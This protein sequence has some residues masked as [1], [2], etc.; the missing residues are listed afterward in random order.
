MFKC[1]LSSTERPLHPKEKVLEQALQWCKM[2]DPS[3][4]YLVVKRV[5]KGE[6]FNILTAYK[7]EIMKMGVL[8][9]R[10]E[11]PKLLHGK[12]FQEHTFQI[13]D[14]K[15]L[16]LK[17]KKSIKPEKEWPLKSMKIYMG[18]RK[19][20]KPPTR[21]G[22]TLMME[23]QHLYLCCF[24]ESDLWDWVT[25]FLKAQND[26]PRPPVLRRHSSSDISKQKFGTMPLVPIRGD[27][28]ESNST[29]LSANQ[30]LRKLHAR[31]TLSMFFPMKVQPDSFEERPEST[32]PEPPEPL[33]EEVGDFGLQVLKS[34]ETSFLSNNTSE[35]QEVPD[36][37]LS[38]SLG[39]RKTCSLDRMIGPKP[40][41]SLRLGGEGLLPPAGSLDTLV[42][43]G[44]GDLQESPQPVPRRRQ[45]HRPCTNLTGATPPGTVLRLHQED[46]E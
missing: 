36:G 35:T 46:R 23:K 45:Q 9:C 25:N 1:C 13:K 34:L 22:F 17:D 16:L 11:P 7:S 42:L 19:K 31:R 37:P 18:I 40:V 20:L 29:M 4:A 15:L 43:G 39:P 5:P 3:S 27:G 41:H 28:H 26:D 24:C 38:L 33:Y 2:A 12:V 8:K 21:W 44:G 6:G 30:T 14:H 32:E 10:E